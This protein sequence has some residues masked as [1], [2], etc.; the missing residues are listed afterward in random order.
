MLTKEHAADVSK[1]HKKSLAKFFDRWKTSHF[2]EFSLSVP[3]EPALKE[4][5]MTGRKRSG[6]D[7]YPGSL[8]P[9]RR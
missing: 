9:R 7:R 6:L 8:L 1:A 3:M 5:E 4:V 2:C